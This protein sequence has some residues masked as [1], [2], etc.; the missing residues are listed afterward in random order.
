MF[1]CK[2]RCRSLLVVIFILFTSIFLFA[3]RPEWTDRLPFTDD[4][5]WGVGHAASE[6]EASNLAKQEILM[7]LCS[8]VKA[9][10]TME[11]S[12]AGG[13][14]VA[15]EKMDSFFGHNT[16]RGAEL[17]EK[18]QEGDQ[19]WILMKYCEDCGDSLI[20]SAL[21][22]YEEELEYDS[23]R[24]YEKVSSEEVDQ[25]FMV[26]RRLK[27]L[28]LQDYRAEDILVRFDDNRVLIM[29]VNFIP[30]DAALS[31]SQ[32]SG[33]VTLSDTLLKELQE[34]NYKSISITGHANPTGKSNEE[35]ELMELSHLRAETLAEYL[36]GAGI[37]IDEVTW[38]GGA[39]TIGDTVAP[40]GRGLNRRVEIAVNL[41]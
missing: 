6:V 1:S 14:E 7:Q 3:D 13:R 29:I 40:E 28:K 10:I 2:N 32:K 34:L 41:E 30:D 4:A 39:V 5:F 31:E 8:R 9:V 36:A 23:G 26:E 19:Y 17:V 25:A 12:S 11:S 22:R 35:A 16:L 21:Y 24:L 15:N 27:E 38:K 37:A 20:K 18:Y 33:L